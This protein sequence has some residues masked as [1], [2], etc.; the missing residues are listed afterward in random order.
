MEYVGRT[1]SVPKPY[2]HGLSFVS[3]K[4]L[5]LSALECYWCNLE[6]KELIEDVLVALDLVDPDFVHLYLSSR[7]IKFES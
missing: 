7:G 6:M 2:F 3:K 5:Y 4:K 1:R